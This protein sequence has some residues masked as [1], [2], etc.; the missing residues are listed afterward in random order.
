MDISFPE[1]VH[2]AWNVC[3]THD[4]QLKLQVVRGRPKAPPHIDTPP[5]IEVCCDECQRPLDEP[6]SRPDDER[7]PCPSCGSIRRLHKVTFVATLAV[8]ASL[9]V[10][11]K[12]Q[13]KGGWMR[14]FRTGEDYTRYLEGWGTRVL[15]RNREQDSY[16]EAIILYDGTSVTS[17]ARLTDPHD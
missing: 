8:R 5:R 12:Q 17:R 16:H 6:S 14:N 3:R 9:R 7:Q 4:R 1:G 10:Q 15:D 2:E 13:G 11:S